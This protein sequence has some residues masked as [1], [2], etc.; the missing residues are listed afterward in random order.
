MGEGHEEQEGQHG[1][2]C[3]ASLGLE[4]VKREE[5]KEERKGALRTTHLDFFAAYPLTKHNGVLILSTRWLD[6]KGL[7]WLSTRTQKKHDAHHD[8]PPP[9]N[10]T[11]PTCSHLLAPIIYLSCRL[12]PGP[13][14]RS[15]TTIPFPIGFSS[16]PNH[17]LKCFAPCFLSLSPSAFMTP[18]ATPYLY[19]PLRPDFPLASSPSLTIFFSSLPRHFPPFLDIY[20]L[21]GSPSLVLSHCHISSLDISSYIISSL[22]FLLLVF[23]V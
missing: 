13:E 14:L 12:P 21:E 15:S 19:D 23:H 5:E 4:R 6:P 1:E 2:L 11:Q 3:D 16:C 9:T 22:F 20:Q 8:H 10:P 17:T 18:S 7:T